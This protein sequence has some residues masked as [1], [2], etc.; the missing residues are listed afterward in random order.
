MASLKIFRLCLT[1]ILLTGSLFCMAVQAQPH[2]IALHKDIQW[3]APDNHPLTMDIYVPQTGKQS[4]PVLV[5]YHGGGWL[6]NDNSIMNSMAAYMASHG[7][8]VVANVNYRLLGDQNNTVTLPQIIGDAFGSLLWIKE[9]I[10][11]Y[12]GDASRIAVTGDSAGGHLASMVVLAGRQL[13]SQPFGKDNLNF[14]PTYLP[15]G[16]TAEQVAARD[17]LQVQAAII[18]YGAFDLY[19]AARNGFETASNVFWQMAQASPRSIFGNG[20]NVQS[21][22]ALYKAVSPLYNIPPATEYRLPPQ[23]LHVAAN[24]RLTTPQ[25]IGAYTEQLQAAG[26]DARFTVYPGRNH[27][28]LDNGCNEYLKICF[29]RDAPAALNDM[30]AFLQQVMP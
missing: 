26:Q 7:S 17:G 30:L 14:T 19:T 1:L 15:A 11:Q 10:G 22:P 9:H 6:I 4:Y 23:F 16:E 2:E 18:S 21:A 5:I 3:A 28:F 29:D 12:G 25:A 20:I 24:D 8:Y 27:A 13:S